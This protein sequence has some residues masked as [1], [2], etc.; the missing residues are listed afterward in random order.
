[1]WW[2]DSW[3]ELSVKQSSFQMESVSQVGT[4][5]VHS[6][7]ISR[8]ILS[9]LVSQASRDWVNKRKGLPYSVVRAKAS[10]WAIVQEKPAA[11]EDSLNAFSSALSRPIVMTRLLCRGESSHVNQKG[12]MGAVIHLGRGQSGKSIRKQAFGFDGVKIDYSGSLPSFQKPG[13]SEERSHEGIDRNSWAL[14]GNNFVTLS[15]LELRDSRPFIPFRC[16]SPSDN[17]LHAQYSNHRC[18]EFPRYN[19]KEGSLRVGVSRGAFE[20][21]R[22]TEWRYCYMI[23]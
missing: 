10:R 23:S 15:I 21:L 2:F 8:E 19:N 4:A 14:S 16:Y 12:S 20:R 1:M 13:I 18:V 11:R 7:E 17:R 3:D 9:F 22:R 5:N 6:S